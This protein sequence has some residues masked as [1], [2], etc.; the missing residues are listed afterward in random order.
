MLLFHLRTTTLMFV[1]ALSTLSI[2]YYDSYRQVPYTSHGLHWN[3]KILVT[4]EDR[5]M[6]SPRMIVDCSP[7]SWLCMWSQPVYSDDYF[8]GYTQL[9]ISS[10]KDIL[11]D[12]SHPQEVSHSMLSCNP[13]FDY[14]IHRDSI[15]IATQSAYGLQPFSINTINHRHVDHSHK[16]N[17]SIDMSKRGSLIKPT[18]YYNENMIRLM[19]IDERLY[20]VTAYIG[21]LGVMISEIQFNDDG[22]SSSKIIYEQLDGVFTD[23]LQLDR[24]SLLVIYQDTDGTYILKMISIANGAMV[25]SKMISEYEQNDEM[26]KIAATYSVNSVYLI[27]AN[28]SSKC[29]EIA[30]LNLENTD[31]LA[32]WT[33]V[34]SPMLA[35]S[36]S[37]E[38]LRWCSPGVYISSKDIFVAA[39]LDQYLGG[40]VVEAKL[41]S[42]HLNAAQ[43][44]S[45]DVWEVSYVDHPSDELYIEH[46]SPNI[47]ECVDGI[48]AITYVARKEKLFSILCAWPCN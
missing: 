11:A 46:Y 39:V 7:A 6:S 22:S 9:Y 31:S 36:I 17:S 32:N 25:D 45:R 15:V 3:N 27:Y 41:L 43:P 8:N 2:G 5:I 47:V 29:I 1:I 42:F 10:A 16:P 44:L 21:N 18:D 14:C 35:S 26:G 19:N 12:W 48:P 13:D 37:M 28:I 33:I 20:V 24:N 4:T 38:P 30:S 40:N 23:C 34:R